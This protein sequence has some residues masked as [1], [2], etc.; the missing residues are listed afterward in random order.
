MSEAQH[1][2]GDMDHI[3]ERQQREIDSNR[4]WLKAVSI[5]AT[6]MLVAGIACFILLMKAINCPHLDCPHHILSDDQKTK[7]NELYMPPKGWTPEHEI[8]VDSTTLGVPL[9][10]VR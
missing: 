7:W 10:N 9:K 4:V 6:L 3:D 8:W 5:M 2:L 1:H